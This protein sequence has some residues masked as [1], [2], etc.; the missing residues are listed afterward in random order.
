MNKHVIAISIGLFFSGVVQ[1][2]EY[3]NDPKYDCSAEET[4]IYIEQVTHGVFAPSPLS[5]PDEFN[6]AHRQ[7]LKEEAAANPGASHCATLL[8]GQGLKEGWQDVVQGVRDF[9]LP[10]IPSFSAVD[11]GAL[12]DELKKKAAEKFG[13]ALNQLGEDICALM[14]PESI[15]DNL[16]DAANK[17]LG[18]NAQDLRFKSFADELTEGALLD[19]DQNILLLLSEDEL[20]KEV[21]QESRAEMREIRRDLWRNF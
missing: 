19:A 1:A 11:M 4:K 14:S 16:L 2:A 18:V 5:T 6:V 17:E 15:K 10:E 13:E 3:P 20:K 8:S 21:S 9:E 7:K 12:V